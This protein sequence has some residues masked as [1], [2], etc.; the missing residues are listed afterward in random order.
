MRILTLTVVMLLTIAALQVNRIEAEKNVRTA[1]AGTQN[2]PNLKVALL[3]ARTILGKKDNLNLYVMIMNDDALHDAF[4]YSE[5]EFGYRAELVLIRRDGRGREVP[6]RFI[7]DYRPDPL[8]LNDP[9]S[10]VKLRP[11]NFLGVEYENSIYNLNLDKPGTYNLSVEY[12]CP[13]SSSE[14]K[15]KPFWGTESGSIASN[16]VAITVRP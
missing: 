16:V 3:A 14:V 10:F 1:A 11:G 2:K 5:L 15:V 6:T 12:A 13:I 4:V 9:T 8:D 7:H